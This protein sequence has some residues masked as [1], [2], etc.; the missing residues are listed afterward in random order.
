MHRTYL[1]TVLIITNTKINPLSTH[2]VHEMRPSHI[3][4]ALNTFLDANQP[5]MIWGSPGVGKS[6]L[7]RQKAKE[8]NEDIIDMRLSQM[9]SV[10][11]RGIP[12]LDKASGRT[13]W[14]P[15]AELPHNGKGILFLDEINSAPQATTAAAYQL[16]LDRRLGSYKVPDGWKIVA[17]GNRL[18]DR[19]IVNPMPTPLKNRFAHLFYEVNNDDWLDWAIKHSIETEILSFIRFRPLM[20]NEFEAHNSSHEELERVKRLRDANA[21]ATPRSWFF[22]SR[23]IARG[24]AKEIEFDVI[25]SMVGEQAAAEFVGFLRYYRDLPNLDV[26]LMNPTQAKVPTEPASLIAIATGLAAKS[27][28]DNMDRVVKYASRMPAEYQVLLLKDAILRDEELADTKAF[29]SWSLD[30]SDVLF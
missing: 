30:N 26:V 15:P 25:N 4:L 22:L 13:V 11:L 7:I 6:D 3:S 16:I 27:T 2:G 10:D 14:N 23:S 21:F 29:I 12:S 8:R 17:A 20:L 24:I 18:T 28:Q 9:D 1:H 19:A 5:V